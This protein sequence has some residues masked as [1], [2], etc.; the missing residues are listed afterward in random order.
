[1]IHPIQSRTILTLT[2]LIALLLGGHSQVNA[3]SANVKKAAKS[4]FSL[5]TF[6]ADGTL[7]GSTRGVFI[8]ENGEAISTWKP[9]VGAD[10]AVVIDAQGKAMTVDVMIG[11]NELYDVCKFKVVGNTTPAKIASSTSKANEK[12]SV[13]GYSIKSL[14]IKQVPIQKVETFMDKYAYYIFSSEA[15][16]NKEGCPFVNAKGE[17]IGILQ[18]AN[19]A[20]ETHAVDAKFMN[21]MKVNTGLSIA[22]PVLRQTSIRTQMP[23]KESEALVM[24]MMSREQNHKNYLKYVQ[25][26]KRLFPQSVDGYVAQANIFASKGQLAQAADEMETAIKRAKNKD[27]AHSEYAKLIY[28]QQLYQPDST[29]TQ[30]SLDK[31]LD[32]ATQA[33]NIN[34]LPVYQHQQAQIIFT[35]GN[36]QKAYDM[37]MALTKTSLRSGE[38]FYEAAQAKTQLKADE[39]E[40]LTLLD[41]AVAACPQPLTPVAAPYV[42]ARGVAYDQIGEYKKA[43]ADYNQYDTLMLGRASHEFYYTRY[44]CNS[45][46]RRYQQALNDI[47][48]AAVLNR[49]EPT[50]LA[51]MASLQLKVNLYEDA[52]K[53]ADLCISLAPSYADAYLIKGL[54]QVQN[55]QKKEGLETLNKAKELGDARAKDFINKYK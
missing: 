48:H 3:Q 44:K 17:V 19:S 52:I 37:F 18:H 55:K 12:V 4:V 23:S 10:S 5:T 28:Q 33:N 13:V 34:P 50:Y 43:L 46:L 21:D 11:A 54:A 42:L 20:D 9:F 31:A 27:V 7:L 15:P 8:G 35:K 49:Q 24:L 16:A 45:Q 32:E 26:F 29:F 14:D 41:S 36:Y 39:K 2:T 6:K 40:I 47:A 38:L 30:W 51:E 1:M 25:D 53:T 22:D